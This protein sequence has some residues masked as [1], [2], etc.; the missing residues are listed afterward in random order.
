MSSA[1]TR[2]DRAA[3]KGRGKLKDSLFTKISPNYRGVRLFPGGGWRRGEAPFQVKRRR[4]LSARCHLS[5]VQPIQRRMKRWFTTW[6]PPSLRRN[7]LP[8]R[9]W[10]HTQSSLLLLHHSLQNNSLDEELQPETGGRS[11]TFAL[12]DHVGFFFFETKFS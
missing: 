11:L 8:S 5:C 9:L 2:Q 6:L 12:L 3:W 10:I 1:V 4:E 7:H